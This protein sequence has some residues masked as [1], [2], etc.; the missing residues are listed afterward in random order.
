MKLILTRDVADLGA[1]GDVVTVK[2]GYGRNYLIPQGM[3]MAWSK[4]GEAQITQIKRARR[5][6][7]IR[8]IGHAEELK[9][10]LEALKIAV[11]ARSGDTGQLFGRITTKEL[12]QAIK[13]AG[14]PDI[15]RH[16]I[17]ASEPIK[18]VGEHT[19]VVALPHDVAAK[20][21]VSV[22]AAE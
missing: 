21:S 7:E 14:G 6:R 9:G 22:S 16:R 15:D 20:V 1:P 12:A 19:V 5:V 17:E 3:A 13:K 8:D 10:E 4:G 2:S 18:H 11:S